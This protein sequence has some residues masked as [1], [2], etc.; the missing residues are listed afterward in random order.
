MHIPRV[1]GDR[2]TTERQDDISAP[3]GAFSSPAAKMADS[4]KRQRFS[5]VCYLDAIDIVDPADLDC[6]VPWRV[7]LPQSL[8]V[9]DNWHAI[10]ADSSK[11][12]LAHL[13]ALAKSHEKAC[14]LFLATDFPDSKL[15]KA[16]SPLITSLPHIE[17]VQIDK[18]VIHEIAM[19]MVK[20]HIYGCDSESLRYD[21]KNCVDAL[22]LLTRSKNSKKIRENL[23]LLSWHLRDWNPNQR[24][25]KDVVQDEV[26]EAVKEILAQYCDCVSIIERVS[27]VAQWE[28]PFR[29]DE[30][31]SADNLQKLRESKLIAWHKDSITWRMDSTDAYL[32]MRAIHQDSWQERSV[33]LLIDY[34]GSHL[35][36]TP[37]V[38]RNVLMQTWGDTRAKFL[39]GLLDNQAVLDE[40]IK[41]VSQNLV[42]SKYS[43]S[44]VAN[45]MVGVFSNFRAEPSESE[46]EKRLKIAEAI[47]TTDDNLSLLGKAAAQANIQM[48]GF[49]LQNLSKA[50]DRDRMKGIATAFLLS[51][52]QDELVNKIQD[53][54]DRGVRGLLLR[55]VGHFNSELRASLRARIKRPPRD[56]T[57]IEL[58]LSTLT[59][60]WS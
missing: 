16:V 50:K 24:F 28:L 54:Q 53:H 8:V 18:S 55:N 36:E 56:E 57:L 10:T 38:I 60:Y 45:L 37:L 58:P 22:K 39:A 17:H 52:N 41:F 15:S 32:F 51:L 44:V 26:P 25:L 3:G 1:P 23:R 30:S 46:K 42:D 27:A 19:G 35:H 11:T 7:L 49:F 2:P 31:L 12:L 33:K 43:F 21:E 9:I 40:E 5:E 34:L 13:D 59:V 29:P 6:W 47:L 48:L 4:G 14:F 20:K